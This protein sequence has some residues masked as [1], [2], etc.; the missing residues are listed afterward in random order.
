MLTQIKQLTPDDPDDVYVSSSF[1][2]RNGSHLQSARPPGTAR[3]LAG[4]TSQ[5]TQQNNAKHNQT[6]DHSHTDH[7]VKMGQN[8]MA[9]KPGQVPS[10]DFARHDGYG[11]SGGLGMDQSLTS[12]APASHG[13][14][15]L[16][17]VQRIPNTSRPNYGY[18]AAQ[19][20]PQQQPPE[21]T[22]RTPSSASQAEAGPIS[23]AQ[24]LKKYGEYL[25]AFEQSEIL[26]YG[27]VSGATTISSLCWSEMSTWLQHAYG[28]LISCTVTLQIWFLGKAD[29]Q[30]IKGNPHLQK[31][32]YGY[33]D[34][35]GDYV[36]TPGDHIAYRC[37]PRATCR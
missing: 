3:K 35:R 33:D 34:E 22:S 21:D 12:R 17:S 15:S 14:G 36:I 2:Q 16:P 29:A 26:Q 5:D 13:P 25:T 23:P 18:T 19:Q 8:N 9:G 10:L 4:A 24:A 31:T 37:D 7:S 28:A 32:N 6:S 30:K 27:Q 11:S 20:Q 1:T